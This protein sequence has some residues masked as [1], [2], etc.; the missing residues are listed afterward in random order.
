M[1]V[2]NGVE[3]GKNGFQGTINNNEV[4]FE[5]DKYEQFEHYA[6]EEELQ[7]KQTEREKLIAICK[8]NSNSIF[9]ERNV[10]FFL[11]F[12]AVT[13]IELEAAGDYGKY[14]CLELAKTA[15]KMLLLFIVIQI[16]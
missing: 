2:V 15:L 9:M 7:N 13:V 10:S 6:Q 12:A 3:N 14:V 16:S 1:H 4:V 5:E 11:A 8:N